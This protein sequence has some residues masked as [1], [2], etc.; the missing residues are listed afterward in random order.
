MATH[1]AARTDAAPTTC[2]TGIHWLPNRAPLVRATAL[3]KA[4][5]DGLA[6][7]LLELQ[8]PLD[9]L[10]CREARFLAREGRRGQRWVRQRRRRRRRHACRD[11]TGAQSAL[12]IARRPCDSTHGP[13]HRRNM[14]GSNASRINGGA[15]V[16]LSHL[17]L[18][19]GMARLAAGDLSWGLSSTLPSPYVK[20]ISLA[21]QLSRASSALLR[22]DPDDALWRTRLCQDGAHE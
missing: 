16:A 12:R 1:G 14:R 9:Q 4:E 8:L 7:S 10:V 11:G 6:R 2:P 21:A 15:S 19:V 22:R 5:R 18:E 13:R 17:L 20:P 3:G